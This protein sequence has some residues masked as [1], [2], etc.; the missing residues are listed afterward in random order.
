MKDYNKTAY[1]RFYEELND[2][3]PQERKKIK[4][5][6]RFGLRESV[7]DMIESLGVPHTEV[8][9]VLVNGVSVDFDYIVRD[10]DEISVYPVFESFDITNVQHLRSKPLRE[11]KFIT[12]VHLGSLAKYM[13]MAGLD[14]TYRNNLSEEEILSISHEEKRAIITKNRNILK[15]NEVTHGYFVRSDVVEDQLEEIINRFHLQK[16]IKPFS[17]CMECNVLLEK[18]E[19]EKISDKIPEKVKAF[20]DEFYICI[21]CSRIY[22]KGSHFSNMQK[23]FERMGILTDNTDL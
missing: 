2:F 10:N 12:D 3:L 1:F 15:R 13:R 11:P 16:V 14:T 8:D 18:A 9:L 17:R 21:S 20:H 19:K 22:W 6:H 4:F 5:L 7:K 23:L